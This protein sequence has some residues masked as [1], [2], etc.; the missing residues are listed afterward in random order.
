[1]MCRVVVVHPIAMSKK[2][3]IE[4]H[5]E[6]CHLLPPYIYIWRFGRLSSRKGD[7]DEDGPWLGC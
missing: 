5:R 6:A 4:V 7:E 2:A 1:M 3:S